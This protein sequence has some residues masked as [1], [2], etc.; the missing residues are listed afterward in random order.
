MTRSSTSLTTRS[1]SSAILEINNDIKRYYTKNG[2]VGVRPKVNRREA[3]EVWQRDK[4]RCVFCG[5]GLVKGPKAGGRTPCLAFDFPLAHGGKVEVDN[6][7]LVCRIHKDKYEPRRKPRERIPDVDNF[8]NLVEQ[9][10]IS[11]IERESLIEKK[12]PE[13]FSKIEK[14]RRLRE[15]IDVLLEDIAVHSR[16]RTMFKEDTPEHFR[17]YREG[18][19]LGK[20]IENLSLGIGDSKE[21]SEKLKQ[22]VCTKVYRTKN[23]VE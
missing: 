4:G 8:A 9:M 21:I 23:E 1:L 16:Y 15:E 7:I 10:V 19:T 2:I 13:A 12:D 3:A 20:D 22:L 5:V 14:V 6:I 11:I 17:H 18:D